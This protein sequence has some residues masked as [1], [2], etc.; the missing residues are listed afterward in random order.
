MTRLRWT[1]S[2][3]RDLQHI[4]DY[5]ALDSPAMAATVVMRLVDAVD[6]L[7]DNP[8]AGRMVPERGD[9]ALRELIRPPYRIVYERRN[10]AVVILTVFHSARAFPRSLDEPTR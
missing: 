4:R 9:P 8:E 1:E 2:A 5:I 3:A 7:L 6:V 10:E